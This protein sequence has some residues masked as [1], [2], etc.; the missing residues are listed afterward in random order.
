MIPPP[1]SSDE[2]ILDFSGCAGTV[3]YVI[4]GIGEQVWS[5]DNA[6]AKSLIK[7]CDDARVKMHRLQLERYSRLS[8]RWE[9]CGKV[10]VKPL[11]E[12]RVEVIPVCWYEVWHTGTDVKRSVESVTLPGVPIVR[13]IANSIILDV[14]MYMEEKLRKKVLAHV[15]REITDTY[16]GY[17]ERNPGWG[18]DMAI[19][20]HSLG[21]VIAWDIAD[22]YMEEQGRK[23]KQQSSPAFA[24]ASPPAA[25]SAEPQHSA[26][27]PIP[28]PPNP[29]PIPS[30][31]TTPQSIFLLGSPVGLFLSIRG[32]HPT[33]AGRGSLYAG[34]TAFYNVI[35]GSD[36]VSYR[37]EPLLLPPGDVCP[38]PEYVP[39]SSG[40][41]LNKRGLLPHNHAE[42][43]VAEAKN[44]VRMVGKIA[45]GFLNGI[46][47]NV[48]LAESETGEE[49]DDGGGVMKGGGGDE[50]EAKFRIC[51]GGN[52]RVDW[53]LQAGVLESELLSALTAHNGYLENR[54]VLEFIGKRL[55]GGETASG[56]QK[57]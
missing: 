47:G 35:H 21:S 12:R 2:A 24:A 33:M 26:N 38:S 53:I 13:T 43:T 28:P 45:Q 48:A 30:L 42:K 51:E 17:K 55:Y 40:N 25:P 37:I 44:K 32:S 15:S 1:G 18:G 46:T 41:F 27:P 54:D 22:R 36:P 11:M 31:P 14:I 4:H 20:G 7:Q 56:G 3:I 6:V 39:S 57:G 23:I 52:D 29:P 8:R 49:G 16:K 10:G 34:S 5:K 9:K 50:S 19:V